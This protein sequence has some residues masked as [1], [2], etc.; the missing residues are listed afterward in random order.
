MTDRKI[1]V[2]IVAANWKMNLLREGAEDH[3]RT[4]TSEVEA[5]TAEVVIFPPF[6]LIPPVAAELR[7]SRIAW[8]GQDLHEEDDGA[9]TGDVSGPQLA[10]AGCTWVL[11]GH[12]ERRRDHGESDGLVARK[13]AAAL[14]NGLRP[15]ICVGET[16]A[17][18]EAG[19]TLEILGRQ[20]EMALGPV[21]E[22]SDPPPPFAIAYEPVWA[23]GTGATATPEVAQ[24][25]HAFIR[26]AVEARFGREVAEATRIVYG[27][28]VKPDN[29]ADLMARDDVDGFLVGGSSL[30]A[31]EFSAIIGCC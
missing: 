6:V 12:S 17:E 25:A 24:E 23:I 22:A 11:V 15:M 1:R 16:D 4:T 13:V 3:C 9:H 18:R 8:G 21:A 19:A 5:S 10:D 20:L 29:A 7:G 27:G 14:R 26:S 30:D 28:S 2:P 31:E